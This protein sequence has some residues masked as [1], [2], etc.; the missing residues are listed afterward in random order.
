MNTRTS[1]SGSDGLLV[2]KLDKKQVASMKLKRNKETIEAPSF[3]ESLSGGYHKLELQLKEGRRIP[4]T[5]MVE[6]HSLEGITS[7]DCK[8]KLQTTM[9]V[10]KLVEGTLCQ[11]NVKVENITNSPLPMTSI[12]VKLFEVMFSCC[13]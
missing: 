3:A 9:S 5:L 10:G 7:P 11:L 1:N 6:Y 13:D 4:Y 8:V 12:Y 2:I